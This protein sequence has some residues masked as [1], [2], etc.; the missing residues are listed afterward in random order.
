MLRSLTRQLSK[1]RPKALETD[2]LRQEHVD[3]AKEYGRT[4]KDAIQ[5]VASDL[6]HLVLGDEAA[7]H[8]HSESRAQGDQGEAESTVKRQLE[9]NTAKARQETLEATRDAL[10]RTVNAVKEVV[11]GTA[12]AF[13]RVE[14]PSLDL[15]QDA[16]DTMSHPHGQLEEKAPSDDSIEKS[17]LQDKGRK[18]KEQEDH[19]NLD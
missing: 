7:D 1:R 13:D 10:G 11:Q 5:D 3:T 4:A 16:V 19:R 8:D 9:Y 18:L 12:P 14:G 15:D 2:Q 6:K 17:R